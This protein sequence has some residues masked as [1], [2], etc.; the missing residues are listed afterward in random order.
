MMLGDMEKNQEGHKNRVLESGWV[1][2]GQLRKDS[3]PKRVNLKWLQRIG[4]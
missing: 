3:L 2:T 1:S 4:I